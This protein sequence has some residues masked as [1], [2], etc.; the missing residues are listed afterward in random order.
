MDTNGPKQGLAKNK[1]PTLRIM[2]GSV[3]V[4][5]GQPSFPDAPTRLAGPPL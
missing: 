4:T 2:G 1:S 3:G 5:R